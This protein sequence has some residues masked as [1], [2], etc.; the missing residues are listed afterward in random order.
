M[1]NTIHIILFLLVIISTTIAQDIYFPPKAGNTWEKVSLEKLNWNTDEV[2]PLYD[3]LSQKNTKAFI[4]LKDGK[5]VIEKYFGTFSQDSNWYWASA[6]KTLTST[7]VGIAQND[8]ILSI[9][10]ATSKYLGKNWTSMDLEKEQLITI[11]HQLTMTS[12]LDDKVDDLFCTNPECLKYL[13]DAGTRWSYHNAPYTILDKVIEKASGK[14]FNLYFAEKIR[15]PIGMNGIWIKQDFNNIYYST[16]RSMARFG[17]LIQNKG[18]WNKDTIIKDLN[19]YNEMANTS[20]DLNK[21]YGYLWWLNGKESY[22]LPQIKLVIKGNLSPEAPNDMF[23]ALGKNGQILNICPKSGLVMVR[24]GESP[25]GTILDISSEFNDDIWKYLNKI[26]DNTNSLNDEYCPNVSLYPN[27]TEDYLN[28]KGNGIFQIY[29]Y[30]IIGNL[31]YSKVSNP[32]LEQQVVEL[33]E[34]NAGLYFVKIISQFGNSY[35]KFIKK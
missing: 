30:D 10:D 33:N 1:K 35:N 34:L 12:G 5:I 26:I 13:A 29:I 19:Y 6:G 21:S 9:N 25:G 7:L 17:L 24:M 11:K 32:D 18:I 4:L 27:P 15:N 8:D 3:F 20:Q 14:N 31:K 2:Q 22:M 16:P 23:S 28:I